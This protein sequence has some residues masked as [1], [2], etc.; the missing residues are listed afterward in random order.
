MVACYFSCKYDSKIQ[1]T[2]DSE[3]VRTEIISSDTLKTNEVSKLN[4]N[5]ENC[6]D[7]LTEL[8][9]SSNFPFENIKKEKVN[10]L[11][12]E[13]NGEMIRAKL[14]YDTDGT[15]TIGWVEY[16][17]KDRKLFNS[18]ANLEEPE[19]LKFNIDYAKKFENCKGISGIKKSDNLNVRSI[20]NLYNVAKLVNLPNKYDYDF[21]VEEK[22]FIKV[23]NELYKS[24][25]FENYSNFKIAKLPVVGNI[26]PIFFTIYDESGQSKLYLITLNLNY[27]IIDKLKLYDSEDVDGGSLSTTYEI[28]KD[29][30]IKVKQAKLVDSGSKVIEKNVQ[31]KN[32]RIS[33]LGN[34]ESL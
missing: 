3:K 34:I 11:I 5:S 18:S 12:D 2:S 29:Y 19:L 13:D 16:H 10:T 26:K 17:L 9:R 20:E 27:K 6:Y 32:Y 24:F 14:F 31:V 22:D 7:Y 1:K 23:P 15:G 33:S 28:S 21:I 8:I 30:K 4:N 25:D